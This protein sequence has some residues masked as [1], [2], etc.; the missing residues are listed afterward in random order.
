MNF[1]W[2]SGEPYSVVTGRD[3]NKDTNTTDRPAGI[4]RNSLTGPSFFEVDLNLSKTI[5]LIPEISGD[6]NS[7]VAGGGYF[8]RR[9]GIRMTISAEAENVLNKV[10]YDRISG[11]LTS[12]FFGQ[13]TRARNGRQISLSA[14]F[15][16]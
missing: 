16:F 9:S 3:D 13:P 6:A 15:N 12:P 1:N 10:N 11:V 2:N 4:R 5:T 14:R 7:P 8:G